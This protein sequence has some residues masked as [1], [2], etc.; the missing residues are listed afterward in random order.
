MER[1]DRGELVPA[2]RRSRVLPLVLEVALIVVP[3]AAAASACGGDDAPVPVDA[4]VDAPYN[5]D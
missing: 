2:P 5:L 1:D 3:L 4:S